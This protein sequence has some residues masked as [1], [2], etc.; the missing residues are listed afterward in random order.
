VG[1][2]RAVVGRKSPVA[3][4]EGRLIAINLTE[5]QKPVRA[6]W[7]SQYASLMMMIAVAGFACGDG[8]DSSLWGIHKS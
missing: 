5:D 8:T 3:A 4:H 2:S 7:T 6:D 1:D